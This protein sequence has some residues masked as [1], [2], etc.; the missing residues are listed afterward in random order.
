MF[1]SLKSCAFGQLGY[2]RAFV[3]KTVSAIKYRIDP[4]IIKYGRN[5]HVRMP[6]RIPSD[7]KL[8]E[9]IFI[10]MYRN[11]QIRSQNDMTSLVRTELNRDSDE[12]YRVSG[13]RIRRIGIKRNMF[14]LVMEYHESD[15][16][17]LPG[18]CPVC[19]NSMSP[20]MNS[21]LDGSTIEV[22]RRCTVC[23]YSIGARRR[24]PGR[25]TFIKKSRR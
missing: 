1:R 18:I 2:P 9:A 10:V 6:Y 12:E 25:Y 19:G 15:S 20:I 8:A 4:L 16:A 13:R 22:K 11:Q 5:V 3:E 24:I 21:T 17:E 7:D 14:Q 23:P